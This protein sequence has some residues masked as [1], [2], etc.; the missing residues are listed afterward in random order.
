MPEKGFTAIV[1]MSLVVLLTAV[2][3]SVVVMTAPEISSLTGFAVGGNLTYIEETAEVEI[4]A[5][6]NL[7]VHVDGGNITATLLTD[8]GSPVSGEDVVLTSGDGR[9]FGIKTDSEGNARFYNILPGHYSLLFGGSETRYLRPSSSDVEIS[10]PSSHEYSSGIIKSYSSNASAALVGDIIRFSAVYSRP[11]DM[12]N[13]TFVFNHYPSG[14]VYEVSADTDSDGVLYYD[15]K[16]EDTG[17]Y[18]W[19]AVYVYGHEGNVIA[20]E[21]PEI[22]VVSKKPESSINITSIDA[23][24]SGD[25]SFD[26]SVTLESYATDT[27]DVILLLTAPEEVIIGDSVVEIKKLKKDRPETYTFSAEVQTCG[28]YELEATASNSMKVSRKVTISVP[29]TDLD[30]NITT[31]QMPAEFGRPVRWKKVVSVSNPGPYEIE[32]RVLE[33]AVPRSAKLEEKTI[34]RLGAEKHDD[35]LLLKLERV[36]SKES[37]TI[38]IEYETEAPT[39]A[40]SNTIQDDSQFWK[41]I[42]VEGSDEVHYQ[43]VRVSVQ[44]PENLYKWIK[45]YWESGDVKLFENRTLIYDALSGYSNGQFNVTLTDTDGNGAPDRME[46]TVPMLSSSVFSYGA[47]S[48]QYETDSVA[49][50]AVS[51]KGSGAFTYTYYT[52]NMDMPCPGQGSC[53]LRN[54]STYTRFLNTGSSTSSAGNAYQQMSDRDERDCTTPSSATYTYYNAYAPALG[55][56]AISGPLWRCEDGSAGSPNT[57]SM[58]ASDNFNGTDFN[59]TSV[60]LAAY[61]NNP[62]SVIMI[63]DTYTINY[64]WCW[65]DVEPKLQ[66]PRAHVAESASEKIGGW[67]ETWNFTIETMDPQGDDVNVSVGYNETPSSSVDFYQLGTSSC[68]SC[69]SFTNATIQYNNFDCSMDFVPYYYRFNASDNS[70]HTSTWGPDADYSFRIEE[71]DIQ[72]D[73]VS[74]NNSMLSRRPVG[75]PTFNYTFLRIYGNDTDSES[76]VYNNTNAVF[77]IKQNLVDVDQILKNSNS[78]GYWEYNFTPDC[79]YDVGWKEWWITSTGY[80]DDYTKSCY[81]SMD[82]RDNFTLRVFITDELEPVVTAPT[83]NPSYAVGTQIDL[84]ASVLDDCGNAITDLTS[85][86]VT[87][88]V[89]TTGYG[90]VCT[91]TF[92]NNLDGTYKC[93]FDS[94]AKAAGTYNVT[95]VVDKTNYIDGSDV[96]EN[97]FNLY[98][99]PDLEAANV[100]AQSTPWGLNLTFSVNVTDVG[101]NVTVELWHKNPNVGSWVLAGTQTCENCGVDDV[102][103]Y[104]VSY[105]CSDIANGWKFRFEANDTDGYTDI[106]AVA[107]GEYVNDDD[108]F[109]VVPNNIRIDYVSGNESTATPSTPAVFV[110]RAYD[111]NQSTYG[112]SENLWLYFNVTSNG[113]GSTYI[114]DGTNTSNSTGYI[115]YYFTPDESYTSNHSRWFGYVN[116]DP[117]KTTCYDYAASNVF[118]VT[119]NVNWPPLYRTQRVNGLATDSQGWGEGWNFSV[120]VMDTDNDDL[121]VT[122]QVITQ[123]SWTDIDTK[124]CP[125]CS[126]WTTINFTDI[127]FTCA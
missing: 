18:T 70:S 32:G 123:G 57:C 37:R 124:D 69:S 47:Y 1:Q 5:Q 41:T 29:C 75:N 93:A 2:I 36:A 107:D 12:E 84:E 28:S 72:P 45:L 112:I 3:L 31:V 102:L 65:I 80:V 64:T 103:Y 104:N 113:E 21:R 108:D 76:G 58:D 60:K 39:V 122:L 119:V 99:P 92:T 30:I 118:N 66:N 20:H 81:K 52:W 90:Y 73:Y 15:M 35:K 126:S 27:K 25:T 38:E 82:S 49:W 125:S 105:N 79:S 56:G 9:V 54:I 78:T 42:T 19:K 106:T 61:A 114:R 111:L 34:E 115:Y 94:S 109:N 63:I 33:V 62:G 22:G 11:A 24:R 86:N 110:L 51:S 50:S 88:Y 13:A 98:S 121:N 101:D 77:N 67:G 8:D 46:W 127:N 59:C 100:S 43:N 26:I 7:I 83:G 10:V 95:V 23:V 85:D 74:G 44:I 89:N 91:G 17:I 40:E 48:C 96:E 53:F 6:T 68:P 55:A 87:F 16:L 120:D 4:W 71:D 97:A 117:G 14:S 116:D